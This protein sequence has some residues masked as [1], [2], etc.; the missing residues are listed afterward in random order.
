[1]WTESNIKQN[2]NGK[3]ERKKQPT[4]SRLLVVKKYYTA[5]NVNINL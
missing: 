1:M 4:S 2:D 5:Q 3:G